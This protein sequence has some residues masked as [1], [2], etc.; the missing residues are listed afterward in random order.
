MQNNL[1]QSHKVA[2]LDP[3]TYNTYLRDLMAEKELKEGEVISLFWKMFEEFKHEYQQDNFLINK[4]DIIHCTYQDL[5]QLLQK[6]TLLESPAITRLKI[7]LQQQKPKIDETHSQKELRQIFTHTLASHLSI[8]WL[9]ASILH[10]DLID[11]KPGKITKAAKYVILA[12]G[13]AGLSGLGIGVVTGIGVVVT[14][15]TI[16]KHVTEVLREAYKTTKALK[17][18][19]LPPLTLID[20]FRSWEHCQQECTKIAKKIKFTSRDQIS[21]LETKYN[22]QLAA[23]FVAKELLVILNNYYHQPQGNNLDRILDRLFQNLYEQHLLDKSSARLQLKNNQTVSVHEFFVLPG[24]KFNNAIDDTEVY[25]EI[26]AKKEHQTLFVSNLGLNR[27]NATSYEAQMYNLQLAHNNQ[28]A[29]VYKYKNMSVFFH[30]HTQQHSKVI[31]VQTIPFQYHTPKERIKLLELRFKQ[32][33][34]EI[35]SLKKSKIHLK[36]DGVTLALKK[37]KDYSAME[38]TVVKR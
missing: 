32:M 38:I 24:L 25:T 30:S 37:V 34:E 18:E 22:A 35:Q 1:Q 29:P 16:I 8:Y 13:V 33:E 31:R 27:R 15:A 2:P 6:T 26:I 19:L 12:L 23:H 11:P 4:Q 20:C 17:H 36:E 7:D 3:Q 21:N 10:L 5:Q 28:L 9:V 14:I